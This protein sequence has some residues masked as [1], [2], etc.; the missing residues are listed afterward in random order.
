MIETVDISPLTPPRP[1]TIYLEP[2]SKSKRSR[3]KRLVE[4]ERPLS[5]AIET[6]ARTARRSESAAETTEGS[7]S[8]GTDD[9]SQDSTQNNP[10]SPVQSDL[11]SLSG[12]SAVSVSTGLSRGQDA[13]TASS[14]GTLGGGGGGGGHRNSAVED[15]T[16]TATIEL[17]KGGCLPGDIVP[18]KI[19]VQHIKRIKSMHGVIVTLYRQGRIDSSPP[20]SLF[21]DLSKEDAKKLEKEEYYPKSRTGLGGLSLTS[22][23][24]CSVFR[25]DLSQ[26][27]SPLLID[28][29]TLTTTINTSVR[30]PPEAF[31]TIKGVPGE[32]ISFKY[33]IEVIVDLGG[34]LAGQLQGGN[35]SM[36]MGL[37]GPHVSI[38]G[39]P[40]DGGPQSVSGW[41]PNPSIIDTD[42]LRREKGVISVVFEV[43]V[44]TVDTA[45]RE[46]RGKEPANPSPSI[47]TRQIPESD[48]QYSS[49]TQKGQL[50]PAAYPEDDAGPVEYS[51]VPREPPLHPY[52][53]PHRSGHEAAPV[54][55]PPPD[56]AN[57]SDMTEKDRIRRAEQ[58][59]LPSQP[60]PDAASAGPSGSAYLNG[61]NIYDAEDAPLAAQA[62]SSQS[63]NGHLDAA[64]EPSAPALEDLAGPSNARS[65]ADDKQELERARLLAE[66]SAPPEFPD[67]YEAEA[68]GPSASAPAAPPLSHEPSA[69][70][71]HDES[72]GAPDEYNS[73]AMPQASAPPGEQLPK[74]ER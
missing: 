21:R 30:V 39:Q 12:E 13:V 60:E 65:A 57:E 8:G 15:R 2:I 20:I 59:L 70:M 34:K 5:E 35:A 32:M 54:Y 53:N 38:P 43:V 58:R 66:A 29:A 7:H 3:R 56:V 22:A 69:P 51:E 49:E 41:G 33:Q 67:D 28:P 50:A 47:Y 42:R 52:W 27:F 72:Y 11:R 31:P 64:E 73:L 18:V 63:P 14:I 71:L 4:G 45:R 10:R 1:R 40:I 62:P 24:P 26:A 36:G 61:V 48:L 74:Y 44:G 37:T 55:V 17:L 16:I 46:K 25:K 23:G 9:Q 68:A 19:S 6:D